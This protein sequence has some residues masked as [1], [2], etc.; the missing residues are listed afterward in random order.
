M[1]LAR[2]LS[3][4]VPYSSILNDL[5]RFLPKYQCQLR[6]YQRHNPFRNHA[7][8]TTSATEKHARE[9]T[10]LHLTRC[11]PDLGYNGK[12]RRYNLSAI[13]REPFVEEPP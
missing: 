6:T 1:L 12:L 2:A 13:H 7:G 3:G 10:P 4:F 11:S 5:S 9:P 8:F